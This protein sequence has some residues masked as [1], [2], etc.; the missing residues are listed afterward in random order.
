MEG[1]HQVIGGGIGGHDD[2]L[3]VAVL[4]LCQDSDEGA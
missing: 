2:Q 1:L 4:D 3:N